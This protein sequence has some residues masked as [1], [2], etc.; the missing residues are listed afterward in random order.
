MWLNDEIVKMKTNIRTG[1]V[2]TYSAER[3]FHIRLSKPCEMLDL[4][5]CIP[6]NVNI[7]GMFSRCY[8][9]SLPP[10]LSPSFSL[11]PPLSLALPLLPPSIS[12]LP[13]SP[14]PSVIWSV[15]C[16]YWYFCSA[17]WSRRLEKITEGTKWS[18]V[19]ER[20]NRL[21]SRDALF[22]CK[23]VLVNWQIKQGSCQKADLECV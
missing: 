6:D 12:P 16:R 7:S 15:L 13:L 8:L 18:C 10:S 9:F 4:Q 19:R 2:R 11:P 17:P 21:E 23:H 1:V 22:W 20:N 3:K 5:L 14:S